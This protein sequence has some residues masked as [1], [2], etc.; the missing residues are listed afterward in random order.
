MAA[1]TTLL[2]IGSLVVSAGAAYA[3]YQQGQKAQRAQRNARQ[4]AI[5]ENTARQQQD[6]RNQ[7]RQERVRRAQILQASQNSGVAESS[8]A[9]GGVSALGTQVGVNIG[10]S[11]RINNSN[12]AIGAF[13][14]AASDATQRA[15]MFAQINGLASS[16]ASFFGSQPGAQSDFAR[17]FGAKTPGSQVPQGGGRS[18]TTP[19]G[20]MDGALA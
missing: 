4:V 9:I 18:N 8:G 3:S 13:Q 12:T 6:I 19:I 5:A 16:S 1:V 20:F 14:Q 7:V 17:W 2:A 15:S 10:S 11:S